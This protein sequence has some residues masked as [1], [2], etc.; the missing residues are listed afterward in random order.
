MALWKAGLDYDHGTGHGVGAYL[1]VHEG[2]QGISRMAMS[3]F[4]PGMIVSNEPGFY[5][6]GSYGIRIE[7]LVLVT[8]E[9][10]PKGGDRPMMG[11]DTLT[12]VPLDL[13]SLILICLDKDE[14][15]WL[16]TYHQQVRR[17]ISPHLETD[18]ER[19]WLKRATKL[20]TA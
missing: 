5:K 18:K 4:K 7:N 16:K 6:T 20:P 15:S 2:P 19:K 1:G 17:L 3:P 10:I 9:Q 12:M 14:I 8:P 13:L 11:F